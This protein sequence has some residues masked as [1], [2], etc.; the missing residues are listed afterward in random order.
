MTAGW[1]WAS[2]LLVL[3]LVYFYAH[4][5]FASI[6]AHVTAMFTPFLV[7]IIGAGAPPHLAV[8]ALA[9]ASNLQAA[10][11]HYGTTTAPIYFGA[12]YVLQREWWQIGF[13]VSLIT[14]GIWGTIG[15]AWWKV[16]GF[17]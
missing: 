15:L 11:T 17:W 8:L 12:R 3:V 16:L 5:G 6:T 13:W 1:A 10:L 9:Y 7:V 14:L 4:Y 2:A